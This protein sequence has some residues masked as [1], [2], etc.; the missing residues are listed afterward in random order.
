MDDYTYEKISSA[1][2]EKGK[3]KKFN[4]SYAMDNDLDDVIVQGKVRIEYGYT[5]LK[6]DVLMNP[7]Y[8]DAVVTINDLMNIEDFGDHHYLEDIFYKYQDGDI[9]VYWLSFGS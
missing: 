4:I 1:I 9:M 7:T 2:F 3:Y 8:L 5:E 6:T